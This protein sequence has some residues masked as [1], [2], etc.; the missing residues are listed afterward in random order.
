[1]N[2]LKILCFIFLYCIFCETL[3]AQLS[4]DTI[5]NKE[6]KLEFKNDTLF[7]STGLKFYA[8]KKLII[9][10][11]SGEAG[12]FRSIISRKA[13]IVPSIGG[14]DKKYENA[15]ENYVDSKKRKEKVKNSL[16][17]GKVLTI[18]KI[19]FS[20]SSKPSFYLVSISSDTDDYNCD[21]K[22][23]LVLKELLLY[24]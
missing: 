15:I 11:S 17:S 16:L 21:L 4:S 13:A 5:I 20:K 23:A 10:N 1:M 18:N 7:T 6:M 3:Y 19:M 8:G 2:I 14:Q 12:N 22:M 24:P 9:G